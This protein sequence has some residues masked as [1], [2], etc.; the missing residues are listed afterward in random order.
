MI[1]FG[2]IEGFPAILGT[3]HGCC[4][5]LI[6]YNNNPGT[7]P[8]IGAAPYK[9]NWRFAANGSTQEQGPPFPSIKIEP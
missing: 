7:A 8:I 5:A 3:G 4:P 1:D 9:D 6:C 2:F